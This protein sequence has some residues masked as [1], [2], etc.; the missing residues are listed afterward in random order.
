MPQSTFIHEFQEK[1]GMQRICLAFALAALTAPAFA[2]PA[3]PSS[4]I[5]DNTHSAMTAKAHPAGSAYANAV[6]G[7]ADATRIE[8]CGQM[9]HG[10]LDDLEKGD[11]KTAASNFDSKMKADLSAGKLGEA[12]QS[13]GAQF[14]KLE[15]RGD[16]QTVMYQGMPVVSTPLHFVKS[17]FVSQ[18]ACDNEGKIAGFFIRPVQPAS[19]APASSSK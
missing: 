14:G 15:S 4:G 17:D 3:P 1:P 12:W 6:V 16:P 10:F 11:F 13:V 8:A 9:S 19:A 5:P 18:L 7:Q 2:Q